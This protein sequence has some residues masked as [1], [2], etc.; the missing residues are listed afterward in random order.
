M[1]D[2]FICP[3]CEKE[4]TSKVLFEKHLALNSEEN[5]LNTFS[6]IAETEITN[7]KTVLTNMV[8][9]IIKPKLAIIAEKRRNKGGYKDNKKERPLNNKHKNK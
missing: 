3:E 7:G 9:T 2:S 1:A 6:K 5:Y 4:Y 8:E